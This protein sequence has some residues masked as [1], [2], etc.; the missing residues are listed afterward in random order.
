MSVSLTLSPAP[1]TTF[2]LLGLFSFEREGGAPPRPMWPKPSALLALLLVADGPVTLERIAAELW[3]DRRPE[4]AVAN[5]RGYIG[6]LRRGFGG[7]AVRT[8]PG[9]YELALPGALLDSDAFLD[10]LDRAE[11]AGS[12]GER[13]E[14]LGRA[15]A[16]WHGPALA[17]LTHGPVLESWVERMNGHRRRA[18]L[19]LAELSLAGGRYG[20]AQDLLRQHL[21]GHPT[22]ESAYQL[23]MRALH[24]AGDSSAALVVYQRANRRLVDHGLLPGPRLR[25]TQ[26]A[27]LNHRPLPPC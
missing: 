7:G 12:P 10:L 4:S 3:G 9:S 22:D 21:V 17:G 11:D 18:T 24:E 14:L 16:L 19:Q 27:I 1:A 13:E 23:L 20:R 8:L 25:G 2:R 15:L 6:I 5:I 26:Q